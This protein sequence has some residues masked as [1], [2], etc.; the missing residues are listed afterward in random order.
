MSG[1]GTRVAVVGGG[2][3]GITAALALADA[4]RDVLLLESRPRLGGLTNSFRRS[5]RG[6]AAAGSSSSTSSSSLSGT[7]S[8]SS[9]STDLWVDNGQHVFLRCCTAYRALLDRLGTAGDVELQPRLDV[10]VLRPGRAP[11]RLRRTGLPA[12]LHLG[13]SLLRYAPLPWADRLRVGPAALAMKRLDPADPAVDARP[14]GQWLAEHGQSPAAVAALWDLVG[15][16]TLNLP[17]AQASLAMAATV[18]QQG[19][20]GAADAADIGWSTVPLQQLHGDAAARALSAAGAEVRLRT[21]VRGLEAARGSDGGWLLRTETNG[22]P[23][24]EQ[25][26]GVV[27]AVP[28]AAAERLLPESALDLPAGWA[29]RLGTSP[30]VDV[31]VRY[32]RRVL[33]EPFAA[34]LDTP[35]QWVF[36]RTAGHLAHD[37]LAHGHPSDRHP[38]RGEEQYLVVSLSA[39]DELVDL[40]AEQVRE[41]I[42]PALAEL[43]PRARGARVLDSFVTR[44]RHATFRAAPGSGALRPPAA[45][46][47]PGLA[48]AGAWTATGWPATMEGAVRS[49]SAAAD[50]LLR[51]PSRSSRPFSVPGS[52]LTSPTALRPTGSAA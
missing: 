29:Q 8:S 31:H 15:V 11:A 16:A 36:D 2:L 25:V 17:A 5:A 22:E 51:E 10:P 28:P 6:D 35:V 47:L 42:V 23:G 4:G 3:A 50:A 7:S 44:E 21:A 34:G 14:F 41:R 18:F 24:A 38:D 20:L 43:L 37:Q 26:A 13:G 33:D 1:A 49:G 39:A 19:L 12:P 30:I 9:S 45:T 27:L 32:D 46:A 52:R 48:V 40:P